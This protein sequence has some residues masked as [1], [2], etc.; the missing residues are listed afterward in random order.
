M[1]TQVSSRAVSFGREVRSG[2]ILR[3]KKSAEDVRELEVRV[4]EDTLTA[5]AG[6][7]SSTER[8]P[9]RRFRV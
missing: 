2:R 4:G 7:E 5:A 6:V 3:G 9:G 8:L 1:R